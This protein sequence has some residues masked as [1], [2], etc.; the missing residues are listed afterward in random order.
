MGHLLK[1]GKFIN[2]C[3]TLAHVEKKLCCYFAENV[4]QKS[5]FSKIILYGKTNMK[6]F[7]L[8]LWENFSWGLTYFDQFSFKI[9]KHHRL[10]G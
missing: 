4:M 10:T 2:T 1:C 6:V 3:E 7:T 5:S 8:S 9:C